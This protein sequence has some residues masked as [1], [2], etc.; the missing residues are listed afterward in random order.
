LDIDGDRRH[1][2]FELS[3]QFDEALPHYHTRHGVLADA[4]PSVACSPPLMWAEALDL[5]MGRVARSGLD[6][7]R[8]AGVSGSA[9]QHG[10]VYLAAN[11]AAV[12]KGADPARPIAEQIA[13]ALARPVAPIW[14]DS[15]TSR[16]CA[17]LTESVGGMDQ[18]AKRTGSR[19]FE[20][21]TGPQIRKFSK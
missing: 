17:E 14:L 9:Q 4:D 16:E 21:F 20:R 5:M 13:P 19:A 3:L 18:L 10:S 11:A 12:L 8:L 1:I 7:D 2:V 15:S 6:L